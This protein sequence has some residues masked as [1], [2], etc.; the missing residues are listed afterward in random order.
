LNVVTLHDLLSADPAAPA[1]LLVRRGG[2]EITLTLPPRPAGT[3]LNA[4]LGLDFTTGFRMTHPS[5]F[6]QVYAPVVMT[7]R[8]L[9]SLINPHSDVGISKLT[10]PIGIAR[11][12]HSAAEI[13]PRAILLFTILINVN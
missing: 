4:I 10:G 2:S 6:A 8:T 12:F 13:G 11:I 9:W 5:P 3:N 1:T 7:S